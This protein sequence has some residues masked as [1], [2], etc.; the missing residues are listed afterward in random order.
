[1]T[2]LAQSSSKTLLKLQASHLAYEDTIMDSRLRAVS[3]EISNIEAQDAAS[4]ETSSSLDSDPYYA[5]LQRE[6]EKF[7]MLKENIEEQIELLNTQISSLETIIKNGMKN[8]CGFT[9]SG[10]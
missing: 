6:S 9:I 4:E 8:S 1:M 3:R 2:F 7:E 5:Y 10:G